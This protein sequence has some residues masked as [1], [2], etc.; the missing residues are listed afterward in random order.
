MYEGICH[1]Y[2]GEPPSYKESISVGYVYIFPVYQ[3]YSA[4]NIN[5]QIAN[6]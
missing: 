1:N 3:F 2:I 6:I 5:M 4:L